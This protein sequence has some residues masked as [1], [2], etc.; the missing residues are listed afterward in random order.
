VAYRTKILSDDEFI[1]GFTHE[2]W[3]WRRDYQL[4]ADDDNFITRWLVSHG[5]KIAYQYHKQAEVLTTLESNSKFLKQCLRW[6]RSNWRSNLTSMFV[7]RHVLI[8]QPWSTYSVFQTTLTH[9]ALPWDFALLYFCPNYTA[10]YIFLGVCAASKAVKLGG[11]FIRYP[12]DIC[13]LPISILFGYFHGIIKLY[14]AMTLHVTAWGSREGAD[15]DD[16]YRMRHLTQAERG[17]ANQI[18]AQEVYTQ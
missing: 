18:R 14:A 15:T 8:Q 16:G 4:N 9:W 2:A 6:S 5:Q 11:H 7:E 13:L 10:L 17:A 1:Y 3:G 12:V